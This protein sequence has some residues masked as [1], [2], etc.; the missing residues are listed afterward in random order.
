[1]HFTHNGRR[2]SASKAMA[3]KR[4]E[5]QK[6]V[7]LTESMGLGVLIHIAIPVRIR[8]VTTYDYVVL[9]L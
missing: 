3:L 9:R 2:N 1:M 7:H 6:K 8:R 4:A 5:S